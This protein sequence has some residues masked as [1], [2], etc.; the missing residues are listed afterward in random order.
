MVYYSTVGKFRLSTVTKIVPTRWKAPYSGPWWLSPRTAPAPRGGGGGR[1]PGGVGVTTFFWEWRQGRGETP[2]P[3]SPPLWRYPPQNPCPGCTLRAFKPL[4]ANNPQ[5]SGAPLCPPLFEPLRMSEAPNACMLHLSSA[6]TPDVPRTRPARSHEASGR[7][8]YLFSVSL[9]EP[10]LSRGR[11][12]FLQP[13]FWRCTR[14][15]LQWC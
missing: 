12:C 9:P 6:R 4:Q 7:N 8:T 13:S 11:V 15:L 3:V 14:S 2:L 5:G 1:R 10:C